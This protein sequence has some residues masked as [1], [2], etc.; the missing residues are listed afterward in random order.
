MFL[1]LGMDTMVKQKDI[2]GIFDLDTAT[3]SKHTRTFLSAAEKSG[4]VINVTYDLPKSFIVCES[5]NN[6]KIYISQISSTTLLKRA[7]LTN[8]LKF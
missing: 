3:V 4:K 8:N 5:G 1:H 7:N 6:E 2:I